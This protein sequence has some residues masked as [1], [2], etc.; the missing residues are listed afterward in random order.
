MFWEIMRCPIRDGTQRSLFVRRNGEIE[1]KKLIIKKGRSFV[2][3][4]HTDPTRHTFALNTLALTAQR[5]M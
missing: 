5:Y 3:A 4:L 2:A 1:V